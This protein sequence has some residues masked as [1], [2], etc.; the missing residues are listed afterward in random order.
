M[1]E[2]LSDDT[3]RKVCDRA[4]RDPGFRARLLKNPHIGIKDAAGVLVSTM[5]RI[6][7]VEKDPDIDVMVVLPDLAGDSAS[8]TPAASP[9]AYPAASAT[10]APAAAA[11]LAAAAPLPAVPELVIS[12]D[13]VRRTPIV[14]DREALLRA[15]P[16]WAPP[17]GVVLEFGVFQGD[18]LRLLRDVFGPPV[19]GYDSF[20]GLPHAWDRSPGHAPLPQGYFRCRPP[21]IDGAELVIGDFAD[22]VAQ[23]LTRRGQP[24]RL[25]HID[26][27]LYSSCATVLTALGPWLQVG[28]V[29][30]FDELVG[31]ETSAYQNW[32]QGEWRALQES[33]IR[34]RALGRTAH[35]QCA[36]QVLGWQ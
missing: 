7:F 18:S 16:E 17:H 4:A 26:C 1:E 24:I 21:A 12:E 35:T 15:C 13:A 10:A 11:V 31:F 6:K 36:V 2:S 14:G 23:D 22:T 19:I 5:L 28:T 8:F 33:G 25:A 30:L 34:C 29:L 27:D 20:A 9:A 3:L 32:R